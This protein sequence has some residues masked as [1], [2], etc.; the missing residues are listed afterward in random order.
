MLASFDEHNCLFTYHHVKEKLGHIRGQPF[1]GLLE[2][3][4]VDVSGRHKQYVM[5]ELGGCTAGVYKS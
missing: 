5:R 1:C 2:T 3:T 4:Y